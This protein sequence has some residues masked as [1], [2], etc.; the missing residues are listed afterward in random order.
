MENNKTIDKS[1]LQLALSE[2]NK[3]IKE[4]VA[5]KTKELQDIKTK[6]DPIARYQKYVNTELDYCHCKGTATWTTLNGDV[7]NYFDI[8]ET[9]M[10]VEKNGHIKLKAG[11]KYLATLMI[12]SMTDD[13][14][15]N[16]RVNGAIVGA[17]GYHHQKYDIGA[18]AVICPTED[19]LL[20]VYL[21]K[22]SNICLSHCSLMVQEI[23][24][25]ITIDPLE[26]VNT[27]QGIE[28]TPVGHIISH[29][30]TTAPSHYL[31]CDGT[32]YNITDYPYLAQHF[33]DSFGS[34]N[35][36]GGDGIT[37]FAVPDLRNRFLKG[38]ENAGIN[39][40]A[41][42]PDITG[43]LVAWCVSGAFHSTSNEMSSGFASGPSWRGA[44]AGTTQFNASK[45][46]SIY[47]NSDTVTPAN[48]TVLYCIKYEPTYFM[49][50]YN[51]N[52][53]QPSMYSEEE[54]V[55][56]CWINGKPL[57]EKTFS[58][59]SPSTSGN[60]IE[61]NMPENIDFIVDVKGTL[62][63]GNQQYLPVNFYYSAK[64]Y[65]STIATR[66]GIC[67]H[68]QFG[69]YLNAPIVITVQ[70]TK[71][72]D[73]P[74]SFTPDMIKDFTQSGSGETYTDE[75]IYN[76]VANILNSESNKGE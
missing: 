19:S 49:N 30:G 38:S 73:E 9:N 56:G 1:N 61:I 34:V 32:E 21:G 45:S 20:S 63:H 64:D 14:V 72:T 25:A 16:I 69:N 15:Y 5:D 36:F 4:Y 6:L 48:T 31:I 37:T 12:L 26:H 23:D 51:T 44:P 24:R 62:L 29:M 52:Y 58:A 33:E 17:S 53:M 7:S 67:M 75:E 42:L 18:S 41:G 22:S 10:D 59:T 28:D 35:Y 11:K 39:E 66:T 2:N 54:R 60:P 27:T 76:E 71:T 68:T 40:E 65:I 3:K 55:V 70:Y 43:T 74:N 47:G 8:R 50:I 13:I 57:Y 46:N